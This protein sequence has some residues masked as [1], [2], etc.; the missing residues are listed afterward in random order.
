M[1]A[2]SITY[3]TDAHIEKLK[4]IQLITNYLDTRQKDINAFNLDKNADKSVL[5]NGRNLTNLGIF[6]K[7]LQMYVEQH[8]AVNKDMT[9]M[10]TSTRTNVARFAFR[11]LLF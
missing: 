4:N 2:T 9:I 8:S 3:L 7:Y 10:V 6:R 11:N 1:K 5:I